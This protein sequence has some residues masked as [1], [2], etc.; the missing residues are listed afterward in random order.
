MHNIEKKASVG[1]VDEN[2]DKNALEKFTP[3]R[4]GGMVRDFINTQMENK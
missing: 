3:D 2:A 1:I 4:L